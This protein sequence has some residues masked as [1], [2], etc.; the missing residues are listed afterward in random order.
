LRRP[1]AD[2]AALVAE[3]IAYYR[4]RAREYDDTAPVDVDSRARLIAALHVFAPAGRVLELACG[5]GQWTVELA[6]HAAHLTALDAS[7]EM[8]ALNQSRVARSTVRYVQADLFEWAPTERYDIVFFSAW[9]SHVPPRSFDG[10]WTMVG[11]CLNE[12]GRVFVI[13]ELPAV[14][15]IEHRL[16]D[17]V[18]PVVERR[19]ST[20]ERFRAVKVFYE[21][22]VLEQTDGARLAGRGVH[23]RIA[24]LLRHRQTS[25]TLMD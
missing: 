2:I 9:L 5:T 6:K 16:P 3:Q 25:S 1:D 8:L 7:A 10:F 21:P 22:A 24:L 14:A 4:A 20:G 15:A 12:E 13:D 17:E 23:G 11:R 19:L 18:A